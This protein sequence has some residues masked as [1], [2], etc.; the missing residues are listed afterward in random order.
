MTYT[1]KFDLGQVVITP[2]AQEA[3]RPED[4]HQALERH[5][6]GDWGEVYPEDREENEL[7]LREGFRLLSA[8]RSG[9]QRFWIIT[10]ADR[11]STCILLSEEY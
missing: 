7:S 1:A 6:V 4:I 3:I 5:R 11:A 9:N 10:E 8:Y 2:G